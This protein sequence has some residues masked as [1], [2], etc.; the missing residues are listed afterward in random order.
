MKFICQ[1]IIWFIN[2]TQLT[3]VLMKT[4]WRR[5]SS[6]SSEDFFK[7]S[8]RRFG[9]D[10][11]IVLVIR[12][13]DVFKTFSRRFQDIFKMSCQYVFK[14]SSSYFQDLFK[15][16]WRRIQAIFKT[17]SKKIFSWFFQDVSSSETVLVNTFSKWL[18]DAFKMFLRHTVKT[19]IYRT[20]CLG[21]TCDKFIVNVQ[22]LTES[23]KFLK[24]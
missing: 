24:F 11:I 2:T 3:S 19:V 17:S 6:S 22:N 15:T 21:H 1:L 14:T 18:W 4:S 12:L 8:S 7:T 23:Q 13:Q 10:Q 9:E 20:I 5:L 16:F